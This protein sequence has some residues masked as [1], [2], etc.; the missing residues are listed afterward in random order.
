MIGKSWVTE[1]LSGILGEA[2]GNSDLSVLQPSLKSMI[3]FTV[4]GTIDLAAAVR[5][6]FGLM[7]FLDQKGALAFQ[8]GSISVDVAK[9]K[10]FSKE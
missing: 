10:I 7:R 8:S 9:A 1:S 5:L 4:S 2:G 6:I 3:E